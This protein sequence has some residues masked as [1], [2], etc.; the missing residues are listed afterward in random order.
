[1]KGFSGLSLFLVPKFFQN[2]GCL[3]APLCEIASGILTSICIL[4]LCEA[5]CHYEIF[6]YSEIV[7]RTFGTKT[8]RLTEIMIA[9][10]Q[11]AFTVAHMSFIIGSIK[12]TIDDYYEIESNEY[13]F[14]GFLVMILTPLAFVRNIA[15]FSF[16][17][18]IGV[19][20][21]LMSFFV[22][23][24]FC[25]KQMY[26]QE[27]MGPDIVLFNSQNYGLAIG[28]AIFNFEGIGVVMPIMYAT[29]EKKKFKKILLYAVMTIVVVYITFGEICYLTY[30]S[31]MD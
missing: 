24:I 7:E 8:R 14:I 16:T 3:F 27:G 25:F 12:T 30:G 1:M 31:N 22:C 29:K 26:E 28:F 23:S 11:F 15:K 19:L 21:I 20:L 13:I 18:L 4:K 6:S 9:I 5:G 2:G 17:F 10:T